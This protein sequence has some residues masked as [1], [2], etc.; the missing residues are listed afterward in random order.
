MIFAA[1]PVGEAAG[2]V[3]AHG[4]KG[5]GFSFRKGRHLSSEDTA[6]LAAAGIARVVVARLDADD[7]DED[8]AAAALAAALA[9]DGIEAAAATT[10]R[11]NLHARVHGLLCIDAARINRANAI[12]EAMT[13]ATL[14]DAAVV[15]PGQMLATVKIIPFAVP[16]PALG[17]CLE[18]LRA[19]T[20]ALMVA[21]F[22][23][24]RAGLIQ[25]R[26]PGFKDSLLAKTER[27]TAARLQALGSSLD[28]AV[29]VDHSAAAV[30]AAIARQRRRRLDPILIAGASAIA[31]RRDVV[32]A[33][34]GAAGGTIVHFGM[35]VDPGNLLLLA[36]LEGAAV[37]GLP[38]CA[39]SPQPNGIDLVLHRLLAGLAVGPAEIMGWGV[40]GLLIGAAPSPGDGPG[41]AADDGLTVAAGRR[42]A[43]IVLAAGQGR[44]MGSGGKLLLDVAGQPLLRAAVDAAQASRARPV[45]VVTG[46]RGDEVRA[47]LAGADVAFAD[48]PRWADGL[49]GSLAAGIGALPDGLDG[50]LV[51]LADMPMVRAGHIDALIDAFDAAPDG[52][53]CVPHADGRRGNP[54]LWPAA[55]FGAL[56]SLAG[57]SGGR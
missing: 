35:P 8:A 6:M 41:D 49:A 11:A 38:G 37:V 7:A 15:R 14:P 9:G 24:H 17:R 46:H 42:V 18:A 26:L 28:D 12:D 16:R 3:L 52:S 57:D 50:A 4:L 51:L 56:G 2:G 53:I 54:V 44:R 40:G 36:H 13:V 5:N 43:A 48:N 23:A 30:A 33:A 1:E 55:L 47:A 32:P 29:V 31:D 21:P 34:I 10:G 20:P 39:R 22:R 45:I 19:A 27:V 25:T